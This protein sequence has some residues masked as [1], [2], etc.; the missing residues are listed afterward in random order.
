MTTL[1][2]WAER[3]SRAGTLLKGAVL[4]FIAVA[5]LFP[6]Y[7]VVLTSLSTQEAVSAAGGLVTVPGELSLAAYEQLFAGGVV[8]RSVLVSLGVTGVG[9]AISLS[10]TVLAAYGL[11]RPGSLLHRP[12][13]FLI[14]MTFLFGPGI[15]PNYLLVSSLGLIDSYWSLILP[16]AVS[17]FNLVVMRAFFMNIPAEVTDSARIDGAS[18][19]RILWRIVLPMSKGVT[20]VIGLFYAVGYW[21]SFFN[22]VLY[23]NDNAKWPLQVVLRQYVLQGQALVVGQSSEATVAGGQ[24]LPP[25][26]ALQMAIV[27]VALL[28]VLFVYPFVQRHFTKGVII[29]AVKG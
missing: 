21:N 7:M 4:T 16:G 1:P 3:P 9:T 6:L 14:L 11:S 25:S 24:A 10:V 20:A 18:E 17:A 19:F 23:L 26:L 2:A 12:M 22:A 13:L 5:V 8:T 28:P 15:V 29:G 27:V